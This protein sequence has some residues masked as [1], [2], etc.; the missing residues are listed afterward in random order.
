MDYSAILATAIERAAFGQPD[1][2][3]MPSDQTQ[4]DVAAILALLGEPE[5]EEQ[6]DAP[7]APEE[8]AASYATEDEPLAY[9]SHHAPAGGVNINGRQYVGGEFIPA[10]Q[11]EKASPEEKAKLD[12]K[13]S[14]P[15]KIKHAPAAIKAA[16]SPEAIGKAVETILSGA[17]HPVATAGK[18]K[19]IAK[20]KLKA[21][22]E[23]YGPVGVAA[24][25]T[26]YVSYYA[27]ALAINPA[28]LAIPVPL[29]PTLLT[30]A[31]II[32]RTGKK[33]KE[34]IGYERDEEPDTFARI[35]E[36]LAALK[37]KQAEEA[38]K[39][40]EAQLYAKRQREEEQ[41]ALLEAIRADDAERLA[42]QK[43]L[44]DRETLI[45]A[46]R[47]GLK[48]SVAEEVAKA[49]SPIVKRKVE[50]DRQG[51]IARVVR[52]HADGTE[53]VQRIRRDTEGQVLE[54]VDG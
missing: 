15:E 12:V 19:D 28:I 24:I 9:E 47:E 2:D 7:E 10:D 42:Y 17:K 49:V 25:A 38:R 36:T 22:Y 3:G 14:L 34:K 33:V 8:P 29:T 13:R 23:K 46:I 37:A 32:R 4:D 27:A 1:A 6:G 11:V 30:C 35:Q 21:I 5:E 52:T 18:A 43:S 20:S 54:V 26:A 48:E 40:E 16:L 45:K 39:A 31:E 51:R 44:D 41:A 50:R 53:S